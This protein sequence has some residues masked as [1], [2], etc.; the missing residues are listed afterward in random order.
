MSREIEA[1]HYIRELL[2]CTEL[3][4]DDMEQET[5]ELIE[6]IY[7]WLDRAPMPAGT[8]LQ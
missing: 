4:M 2:D 3:N 1:I 8:R 7:D 5:V 6:E